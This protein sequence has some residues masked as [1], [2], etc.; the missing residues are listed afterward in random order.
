MSSFLVVD[1]VVLNFNIFTHYH[2]DPNGPYN[3]ISGPEKYEINSPRVSAG[4]ATISMENPAA[5]L[6]CNVVNVRGSH[7][8][9]C[10]RSMFLLPCEYIFHE[11]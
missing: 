8:H 10:A 5:C 11:I 1:E 4:R 3:K 6:A 7:N 9:E 2:L